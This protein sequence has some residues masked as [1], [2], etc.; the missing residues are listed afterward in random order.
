MA[1]AVE[2]DGLE[3]ILE[4]P[5]NFLLR[6]AGKSESDARDFGGDLTGNIILLHCRHPN[7]RPRGS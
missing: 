4:D 6:E 5:Y 3:L 1:E 2:V 7:L